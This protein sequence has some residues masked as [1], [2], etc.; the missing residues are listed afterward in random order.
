[1]ERTLLEIQRN[2]HIGYAGKLAGYK[3]GLIEQNGERI[4]VTAS[5]HYI[6]PEDGKFP[7]IE[8]FLNGLLGEQRIHFDCWMKFGVE[9]L[10]SGLI[11][12]GQALVLAGPR[13]C[14]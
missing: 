6:E 5:P 13:D 8:Q 10:R 4:L 12:P 9:S 3:A 1:M 14:G 7:V 2:F 11:R